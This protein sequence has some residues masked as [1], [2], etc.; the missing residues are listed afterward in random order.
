MWPSYSKPLNVLVWSVLLTTILAALLGG[1]TAW[2]VDAMHKTEQSVTHSR[3]VQQRLQLV[4]VLVQ[5]MES[6]QRGYLLA[7]RE[8]YLGHYEDV[9]TTLP[10]VLDELARLVADNPRQEQAVDLLRQAVTDK[11]AELRSTIAEQRAGHPDA[12]RAIVNSD[13]GLELLER[14]RTLLA[15][16]RGEE[17]RLL[18]GRAAAL[19]RIG[20][21]LKLGT[22]TAF[23]TICT[24]GALMSLYIKGS[25][26]KLT[27]AMQKSEEGNV[28]QQLALYAA[29]L[30]WWQYDVRRRTISGDPRF[31]EILGV[32]ERETP[33]EDLITRIHPD[34]AGR[35]RAAI[36]GALD[37]A[38][39]R[40]MAIEARLRPQDGATRWIEAHALTSFAGR[41]R[42]RRA[43]RLI[44]TLADITER[45]EQEEKA[46]LLSR[47]INHRAKNMLSVVDAIAHRIAAGH[48][49]DFAQ[50]FSERVQALAANQDLL[51]RKEWEG[52][53]A[54]DLARAQLA[55]FAGLIG[56][57]ITME[58]PR[59]RLNGV[60][61]Q[62]IGLALHEL[63][64]NA[65]KYGAL[66]AGDGCIDIRWDCDGT[67]F[68]MSW[69]ERGGPP[70]SPPRAPGFGTTVLK[71]MAERSLGGTVG[72]DYATTG[73][74]W[75]LSCPAASALE[76]GWA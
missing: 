25:F 49:Q 55:H 42:T 12:A 22:L 11:M 30:G 3:E 73:L 48:P 20:A 6:N 28:R 64:T 7:G 69:I 26:E 47:E 50:Q 4:L 46:H 33:E 59:L 5:R 21:L 10:G 27:M 44:G 74:T 58:G 17:E 65:G 2:L 38:D 23:L 71:T 45:K 53:G 18:S 9:E 57:R 37:L 24:L 16:M 72:L 34:D 63:A 14:I 66:S 19:E 76:P 35:M 39:P 60:S 8:V 1:A 51:I 56:S 52:V 68:T 54:E 41:G 67:T 43:T 61:A 29:K 62:A 40:P 15:D 75:R 32:A 31:R 36:D 70:V 13:R